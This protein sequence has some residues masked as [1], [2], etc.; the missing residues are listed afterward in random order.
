M[1][2]RDEVEV[3]VGDDG[4]IWLREP[5]NS[6]WN[7]FVGARFKTKRGGQQLQDNS[8]RARVELFDTLFDRM[9]NINEP[10]SKGGDP[11]T[12]ATLPNWIKQDVIF[13]ALE[14]REDIEVKN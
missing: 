7:H 11:C 8:S 4:K 3:T 6:E 10:K 5:S 2:L 1:D 13:R 9:E 12:C 14:Q